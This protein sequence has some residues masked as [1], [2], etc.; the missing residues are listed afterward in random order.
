MKLAF[1]PILV[2][3]FAPAT[4][5]KVSAVKGSSLSELQQN[6]IMAVFASKVADLQRGH[7][8]RELI[9]DDLCSD[10]FGG[11]I[12][13]VGGLVGANITCTCGLDLIP[14]GISVGCSSDGPSCFVPDIVC[15]EPGLSF[16]LDILSVFSGGF[17]FGASVCYDKL[18]IGGALDLSSIP[19]CLT[20]S[21]TILGFL[22]I[23]GDSETG[24][25]YSFPDSVD[26]ECEATVGDDPC[27]SC[28][29]CGTGAISFDCTNIHES[30]AATCADVGVI[31]TSFID[32]LR[33]D[34]VQLSIDGFA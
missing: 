24:E 30:L 16:S 8:G 32:V 12:G 15:G 22:G 20:L 23:G 9:L 34:E 3:L 31:P 33:V 6:D 11:F 27:T 21:P 19:F 29:V 7:Q 28:E 17:P 25:S 5:K 2:A 4:G 26:N 14:P 10:I 18:M 13:P 1:L